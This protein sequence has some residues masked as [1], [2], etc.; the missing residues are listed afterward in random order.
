VPL[1][2]YML[3]TPVR[4]AML[5]FQQQQALIAQVAQVDGFSACQVMILTDGEQYLFPKQF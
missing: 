5:F 4:G 3:P 1:P 2:A